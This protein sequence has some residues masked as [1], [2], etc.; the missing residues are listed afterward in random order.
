MSKKHIVLVGLMGS[1]KSVIGRYLARSLQ[2]AFT[3]TDE[4]IVDREAMS[5]PEIFEKAGE[6]GFRKVESE[7]IANVVLSK[8]R[9]IATGGGV[10][11]QPKNLEYLRDSGRIYYLKASVNCLAERIQQDH[12]RPLLKNADPYEVLQKLL[13]ERSSLYEEADK[14]IKVDGKTVEEISNSIAQDFSQTS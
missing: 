9:V 14:I 1:G 4:V 2:L 5:I 10:V 7:V 13:V 6:E 12:N 3:D 11:T 8:P